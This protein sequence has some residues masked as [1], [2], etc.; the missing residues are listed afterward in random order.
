MQL[1]NNEENNG[2]WNVNNIEEDIRNEDWLSENINRKKNECWN[3]IVENPNQSNN[4]K[5]VED[6]N[7]IVETANNNNQNNNDYQD[8]V[9]YWNS[10]SENKISKENDNDNL[11]EE[12]TVS[13]PTPITMKNNE[14]NN[15]VWNVNNIEEDIRNEDWLSENINRKKNECWNSIVE[16]PNQSNNQK[17]VEDYNNI[18]ETAN[19]NNQ[20]NNDYQDNVDYWNSTSENKISKENDNDNL[21][22][23]DTVSI[24]TPITTISAVT[25]PKEENPNIS[26]DNDFNQSLIK[27]LNTLSTID[28]QHHD[29][30][31]Y[32]S[33]NYN[34]RIIIDINN[35]I[36]N[37][38]IDTTG[39]TNGKK[40]QTFVLIEQK[41]LDFSDDEDKSPAV[42]NNS[43]KETTTNTA[44]AK[45]KRSA[46]FK[47]IDMEG[48]LRKD[49][50]E[51]LKKMVN[52]VMNKNLTSS[53]TILASSTG[54][55]KMKF[56]DIAS[57]E[58]INAAL[59]F[60]NPECR[61]VGRIE[62]YSCRYKYENLESQWNNNLSQ[63]NAQS[64]SPD[65]HSFDTIISPFGSMDQ[66]S[67]RR[68]LFNLIATLN[69]SYPDYDFSDVK[70]D[71]FTKQ[72]SVPMVCNYINNTLFNLGRA[73]IINDL[74]LW[75]TVDDI[76]FLDECNIYS[77][78]PDSDADPNSD[79]GVITTAPLQEDEPLDDTISE[80]EESDI[81]AMSYEEYVMGDI[82]M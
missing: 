80:T 32:N 37:N 61:V 75:Q 2:V 65:A 68:T 45:K 16:N 62:T 56:L 17:D 69:A 27:K 59:V 42:N 73:H 24:P 70:P 51:G 26:N 25:P 82:E 71:Q 31:K 63:Q 52:G 35:V 8:N 22:E 30:K 47:I 76:I 81:N 43:E 20:N 18:V 39:N 54:K 21:N 9:D 78:N 64:V 38:T 15:G 1:K 66:P 28:Q 60:E 57:L 34:P 79:D 13:I 10:T 55:Q 4:Q 7:N 11:N 77:F 3:S 67:S 40:I 36:S 29:E 12:D 49:L 5:D 72:P 6:Y 19:N 50:E 33:H 44:T 48:F 23:E 41:L 14:E 74:M 58:P 46:D 53:I